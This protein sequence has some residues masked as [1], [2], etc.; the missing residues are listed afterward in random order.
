LD[1]EWSMDDTLTITFVLAGGKTPQGNRQ[2]VNSA[3]YLW[4]EEASQDFDPMLEDFGVGNKLND[5]TIVAVNVSW[6]D[7][8]DDTEK[9][10][11]NVTGF[12]HTTN[13]SDAILDAKPTR[14]FMPRAVTVPN[15]P[16]GI[17]IIEWIVGYMQNNVYHQTHRD[18]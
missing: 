16:T 13:T 10:F 12:F 4:Y 14:E 5:P 9:P 17:Q 3:E 8:Y 18:D 6:V 11:M 1:E 2:S 15:Y 7:D